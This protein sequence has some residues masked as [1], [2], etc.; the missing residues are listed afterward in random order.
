MNVKANGRIYLTTHRIIFT[1]QPINQSLKSFSAPFYAMF[2]LSLEQPVFGANYIKGKVRNES[3]PD[4]QN[5]IIFKLKFSS[6]GAIEFGQ[7]MDCAAKQASHMAQ[8][9]HFQPPPPYTA[10][11]GQ[12]YQ[13]FI[14]ISSS[15]LFQ[16][17]II[18][19]WVLFVWLN[20][21]F[22]YS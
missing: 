5:G 20:T 6:G 7:A 10:T 18:L 14:F 12:F 13:V 22:Y 15:N 1:S 19:F 17:F 16:Q 3:Q 8:Q 9:M 2:D 21:Y 11:A 4:S